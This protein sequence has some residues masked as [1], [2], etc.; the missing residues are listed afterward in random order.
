MFNDMFREGFLPDIFKI[1]N[2]TAILKQKGFKSCKQ[3]YRPIRL[4]P[5]HSKIC[6][7]FMHQ[8]LLCHLIE[9]NII[10]TRQAAYMQGDSTTNQL[11]YIKHLIRSTWASGN[12]A[13]GIFLDVA[14]VFEKVWHKGLATKLELN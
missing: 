2:I 14:A 3:S 1:A 7:S 8:R 12:I 6:E 5:M 10:S 4:L 9:N 11:L 13:H